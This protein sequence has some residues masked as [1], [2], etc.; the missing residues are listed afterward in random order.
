[1]LPFDPAS[2]FERVPQSR[3][4][5]LQA[6]LPAASTLIDTDA[7]RSIDKGIAYLISCQRRDGTIGTDAYAAPDMACTAIFGLALLSEGS[8]PR[9][10]PHVRESRRLLNGMLDLVENRPLRTGVY[11]D[12]TLVQRKIGMNADVF[13]AA[14]YFS[15]VYFEAPGAEEPIRRALNKLVTHICETQGPDGTW[16]NRSWAPLLGTVLGWE[17]LRSSAA[18]GIPVDA[19]A[20][21]AGEALLA[22][23]RKQTET[24]PQDWMHSFYKDASSLR[25]LYSLNYRDDP[26]FKDAVSRLL[27]ATRDDSRPFLL[28]GGEEYL[29][30]YLVTE[31]LLKENRPDWKEWYP[32][33]RKELV[34]LQNGDGSWTGHHCIVDRTFCTSAALLTLLAP[35]FSLPTSEL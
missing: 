31:C 20:K 22:S 35:R 13:L 6:A 5:E 18:A 12:A 19:S 7:Q 2:I 25:V 1:M 9:S 21:L 26:I 17:S 3:S 30:F 23:L 32:R 10:G 11:E 24:E 4:F 16:G 33:V 14:L 34:R 28:A 29:S 15:E 27:T 8:T